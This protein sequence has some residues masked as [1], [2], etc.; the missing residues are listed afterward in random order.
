L[1]F[2]KIKAKARL[3]GAAE[4]KPRFS[5]IRGL[6]PKFAEIFRTTAENN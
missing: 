4:Q 3:P 5:G 6:F 1:E 2:S